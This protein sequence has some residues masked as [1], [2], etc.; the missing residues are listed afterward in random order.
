MN[1]TSGSS[2]PSCTFFLGLKMDNGLKNLFR[3]VMV[4]SGRFSDKKQMALMVKGI[5][6][7]FLEMKG[8]EIGNEELL[9]RLKAY[10]D[11]Y[12]NKILEKD[13]YGLFVELSPRNS[14]WLVP[15]EIARFWARHKTLP[16]FEEFREVT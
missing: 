14:L 8:K 3:V 4:G 9:L 10:V 16:S 13:S 12:R 6:E 11:E 7:G 5:R 15:E 1:S 2:S